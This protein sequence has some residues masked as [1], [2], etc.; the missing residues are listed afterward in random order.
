MYP[1]TCACYVNGEGRFNTFEL[2][3]H[4]YIY[5]QVKVLEPKGHEERKVCRRRRS[6]RKKEENQIQ[7]DS[8]RKKGRGKKTKLKN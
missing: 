8:R 6:S 1:I 3:E 4:I 7:V 5:M 2:D